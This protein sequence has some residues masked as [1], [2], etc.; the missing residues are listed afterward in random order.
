MKWS[1]AVV[2]AVVVVG[3]GCFVVGVVLPVRAAPLGARLPGHATLVERRDGLMFL[4]EDASVVSQA[5]KWWLHGTAVATTAEPDLHT[6]RKMLIPIDEVRSLTQVD[7]K[8]QVAELAK[9]LK[10]NAPPKP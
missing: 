3:G 6:S 5:G 2:V 7:T 1:V 9:K 8:K 10:G 4:L